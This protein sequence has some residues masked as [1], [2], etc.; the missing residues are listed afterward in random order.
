MKQYPP[1][2]QYAPTHVLREFRG[3]NRLDPFSLEDSYATS[4]KNLT[5]DAYPAFSTRPGS[6]LLGNTFNNPITGLYTWKNSEL[7]AISGGS[8]YRYRNNSW[9]NTLA[10]GLNNAEWSFTNFKGS[11]S[12]INLIGANGVDPIKRYDG[13]T[14]QNLSD[15]PS[16]GNYIITFSNRLFCAV[17]NTLH[18][19]ELNVP[20]N[21]TNEID[22]DADPYKMNI[23][24][25]DGETINSLKAG[26]GYVTIFKP[27]SIH[28]LMGADPSTV[29]TEPITYEV[30]I[31]NHK[32]AVTLNGTMYLLHRTGIYKYGGGYAPSRNFSQP[33][34]AYIDHMNESAAQLSCVGTDGQKVYFG[35]PIDSTTSPDT[36]LVYDPKYDM[37]TVWK[38]FTPRHMAHSGN[39]FYIGN[40]DGKV[41]QLGGTT[42]NGAPIAWERIFKP[43]SSGSIIKQIRWM[44]IW[45]LC[46]VPQGSTLNAYVSPS[47]SGDDWIPIGSITPQN[48]IQSARMII[49]PDK[50]A[51]QNYIR[52]KLAG[53]GPVTVYEFDR[54]QRE[55]PIV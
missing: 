43:F 35:I 32:C 28:E 41:V 38:D 31:L 42:D 47:Y 46:D 27:N 13:S 23:N 12:D 21:W 4:M 1:I 17:G 54:E 50:L 25:Q 24:T 20:T 3:V 40:H 33:I 48:G 37:W 34:Q 19:S 49:T 14:V 55:F 29:R 16:G 7:H 44:M 9:G 6:S 39:N 11:L 5:S 36:I 2:P 30:G 26:I 8:W 10:S 51:D 45:L 22:S 18:A 15:A 52:L 53:T